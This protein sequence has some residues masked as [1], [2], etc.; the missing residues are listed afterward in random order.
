MMSRTERIAI[1]GVLAAFGAILSY[2]EAILSFS[3]GIPG[4]KIGLANIAVIVALYMY[5]TREA[6]GVN[7]VRIIVVG[8]LFGNGFS[9]MFSLA[10]ALVSFL[11]MVLVKRLDL[12]SVIGVSTVGGVAHNL[13]QVAVAMLV[14]DSYSVIYYVPA[15]F[16]AG[17]ITGVV[18]G[19]V[20]R[21]LLRY[22]PKRLNT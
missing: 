10:G 17:I 8:L 6:L 3:T 21:L 16:I 4:V 7:V 20:G 11:V 14:V 22:V 2:I 18:I 19:F 9:V 5:G 15:L 1:V 13:G 12:F